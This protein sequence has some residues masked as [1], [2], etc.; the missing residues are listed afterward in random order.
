MVC[1]ILILTS[2]FVTDSQV[3]LLCLDGSGLWNEYFPSLFKLIV[4]P[5]IL[6]FLY[7][8]VGI[9]IHVFVSLPHHGGY[10]WLLRC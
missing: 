9:V 5:N 8:I 2:L 10:I 6:G 3:M 4:N 1:F 7:T